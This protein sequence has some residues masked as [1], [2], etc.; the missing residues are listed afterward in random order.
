MTMERTKWMD[1]EK[2]NQLLLHTKAP[3][4]EKIEKIIEKSKKC[5]GLSLEETAY[6]INVED[7]ALRKEIISAAREVKQKVY[8]KR[9]VLFSPLYTS[10]ECVNNCLY[11][12]FRAN[13]TALCRKTLSDDEILEEAK[14]IVRQGHKRILLICGEH[15]KRANADHLI[16]AM[17]K[18]YAHPEIDCRRINVE[19]APMSVEEYR[20]LKEA[21]IGTYVI[22]QE[23]YH[24]ETYAKMHPSGMKKDYDYRLTAIHRA[25]EGG[26]DD[27]GV[28]ALLGLYDYRFE[29]LALL[30]H[31]TAFETQYGVGPHTISVP[32]LQPADGWALD[33]IPHEVNDDD[34]KK[35]V[36]IFRLSVPYTGIILSTRENEALRDELMDIGI[37]QMSAGSKTTAGG[38]SHETEE[39]E[40]EGQ[41]QLSDNRSMLQVIESICEKGYIPSFCTAC[42][43]RN[44]T[45]CEFMKFAKESEIHQFCLPNAILTFKEILLDYGTE[46]LKAKGSILIEHSLEDMTDVKMREDVKQKLAEIEEG[47]RDIFY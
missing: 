25:F 28:G 21:G 13:N 7:P 14:A 43:R 15:P 2:I 33:R 45:G 11:C 22:F 24:R 3:S 20:K 36:A 30:E 26:I 41:F 9:V 32:R 23:T 34:F 16:N 6:L 46:Q 38:Y 10:S 19:A 37:T 42:Y 12:G 40:N 27:V 5:K 47:K 31:C 44:R 29:V 39:N 17:K 8:G 1:E 35:I 4:R 18:I